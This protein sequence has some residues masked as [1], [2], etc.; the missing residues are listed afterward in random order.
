[1]QKQK[2]TKEELIESIGHVRFR[3]HEVINEAYTFHGKV[4]DVTLFVAIILSITVVML[5]TVSYIEA[6]YGGLLRGLEWAFTIFFTLEYIGRL[7]AADK[8]WRY[9]LSFM[10]VIDFI[11]IIP[12]YI[13]VIFPGAQIFLDLRIIRLIRV[14]RIFKLVRYLT[15][16]HVFVLAMKASRAK[17]VVFFISVLILTVVLGTFMYVIEGKEHGFT[18]IPKSIYW[19]IVT[20]TTVGY[21]DIAPGTV[22]GQILSSLIMIL[23][24][25]I[26]AVPT[27]IVSAEIFH[28]K[29]QAGSA[30]T[31]IH[32]SQGGQDANAVYCK[33]CGAKF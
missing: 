26:I 30:K 5:E 33:F 15:E 12:T 29:R 32:C 22:L 23:G 20:L 17:I 9:T 4:F 27:G 18:S 24:Y 3:F 11:A 8:P 7:I 2:K 16:V 31:C 19:A 10:G 13:S 28:Q 6:D 14:F 1:M 25:A 21:G